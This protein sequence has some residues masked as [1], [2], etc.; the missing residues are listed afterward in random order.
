MT[1]GRD[2]E[3]PTQ[4]PKTGWIDVGM[5]VKDQVAEDR[6][7]LLAAG[8]A[9]YGLLAL[10]PAISAVMALGGL[11]FD[12]D[13]IVAQIDRL[14]GL[15]PQEVIAIVS[16]Q[17]TAVTGAGK[18]GL[19]FAL[20]VGLAVALFSASKGMA[21][22]IQGL[23]AAYDEEETRGFIR[24]MLVTLALTLVLIFGLL[25]GLG[26]A[27]AMP[28]VLAFVN[29]GPA[30]AALVTAGFCIGMIA[31]TVL[32]LSVLY[33]FAPSRDSAE[34]KWVSVGAV[35]GCLLWIAGSAGFA[36][37]VSNFGSY[38]ESF[39]TVAGVVVLLMWFWISAFIIL[40]GAELN[41]EIEAQT[42][43]DTTI[44]EEQ[45]MGERGAVKADTLGKARGA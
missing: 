23:N 10:F 6:I 16:S 44:G 31:L 27:L 28:A 24:R 26:A 17:A 35:A 14:S 13:Q 20:I 41:A 39:G 15:V 1:R 25:V 18:G 7:G 36:F 11:L 21:S 2:A 29:L 22:L 12:P 43:R 37:Y 38:N 5:R 45:P 30:G 33:R 32:G 40:L 3:T 34:W 19:G 42:R 4:I 8:V 9:F